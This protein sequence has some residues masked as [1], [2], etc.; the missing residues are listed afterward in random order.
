MKR[1]AATTTEQATLREIAQPSLPFVDT[2]YLLC[3]ECGAR[4]C[5]CDLLLQISFTLSQAGLT[6][7]MRGAGGE[8]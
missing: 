4:A 8:V 1:A 7:T 5:D 2:A 3:S 6:V